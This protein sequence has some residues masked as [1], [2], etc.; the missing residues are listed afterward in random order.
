MILFLSFSLS[1]SLC[2]SLS[3]VEKARVKEALYVRHIIDPET[4]ISFQ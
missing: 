3:L 2:L 4:L 1:F